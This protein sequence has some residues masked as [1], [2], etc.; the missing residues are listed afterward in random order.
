MAEATNKCWCGSGEFTAAENRDYRICRSCGSACMVAEAAGKNG[1]AYDAAYWYQHQ[2]KIGLPTLDKRAQDDLSD[3][4]IY[5]LGYLL[6]YR[7]PPARVLEIGCAHGGFLKLLELAGF[8]ATGIEM[9]EQIVAKGRQWFGV[10]VV[11]GPLENLGETLGRFDVI[12]MLDVLEHFADPLGTMQVALEHL[13]PGG[14]LMIQTPEFKQQRQGDWCHY[15]A[16]EHVS[17]FS[18]ASLQLLLQ[19]VGLA[20]SAF[21]TPIF[22]DDMFVLASRSKPAIPTVEAR[23]QHLL[24][25][26]DG[27]VLL[28]LT[29]LYA[30]WQ[31]SEAGRIR[32]EKTVMKLTI[33]PAIRYGAFGM[34]SHFFRALRKGAFKSL[35]L[36]E[37]L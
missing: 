6:K 25:H 9:D 30:R 28:A 17:L 16:P 4:C 10:N 21:E 22:A 8:A 24:S 33:D 23:E 12:V 29:D 34:L 35:R 26:P 2:Q 32:A 27:R 3:R 37:D 19:R 14:M 1:Q 36:E 15:N 7:L 5:W 20:W 31:K 18:R 11:R 13:E